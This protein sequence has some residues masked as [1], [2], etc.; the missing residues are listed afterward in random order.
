MTFPEFPVFENGVKTLADLEF[1][2]KAFDEVCERSR[3]KAYAKPP[4]NGFSSWEEYDTWSHEQAKENEKRIQ[5]KLEEVARTTGRTIRE[6]CK[7]W[8][9]DQMYSPPSS[10]AHP[11]CDCEGLYFL[12]PY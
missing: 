12:R 6:V 11:G 10:I 4:P 7:E 1:W 3:Q 9:G 5:M 8:Y 2:E